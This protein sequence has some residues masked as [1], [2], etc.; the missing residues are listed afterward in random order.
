MPTL[1]FSRNVRIDCS[2]LLCELRMCAYSCCVFAYCHWVFGDIN[3]IRVFRMFILLLFLRIILAVIFGCLTECRIFHI[4][5]GFLALF[6]RIQCFGK[7]YVREC[8]YRPFVQYFRINILSE[9]Y[10][11]VRMRGECVYVG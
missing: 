7:S 2:C 3:T 6:S 1:L 5:V 8:Y 4:V 11:I 9:C 10:I